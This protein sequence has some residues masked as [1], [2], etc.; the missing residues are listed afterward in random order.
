METLSL[1][2]DA[3]KALSLYKKMEGYRIQE[4]LLQCLVRK[5]PENIV[6]DIVETKVKLLNLFYSTGIQATNYMAKNILGIKAVDK[7]LKERDLILV[8]EIAKLKLS[9]DTTRFN[10]SFATKY[11]A[12]HEPK[13]FPIYDS[14]VAATFI[15][16][17]EKGLL[18]KYSY[19]RSIKGTKSNSYTKG[20]FS[21]RLKDYVFFVEVYDYFMD[22]YDL[23]SFTYREIDSYIWGAFKIAGNDFEI[24]K[25]AKLD[26]SKIKEY[27]I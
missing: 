11:C 27:T 9:G 23:K 14:I 24:E 19:S 10:Y 1:K 5:Y 3:R 12:L 6:S 13:K 20:S 4:E 21:A 26:K 15:S 8:A 22:L 7:R 17:F 16:L 25:M 2:N 18:P